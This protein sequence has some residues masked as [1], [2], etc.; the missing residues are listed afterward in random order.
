[1]FPGFSPDYFRIYSGFFFLDFSRIF[2]RFFLG[3]SRIFP[4][5]FFFFVLDFYSIFPGCFLDFSQIIPGFFSQIFS[6]DFPTIFRRFFSW[7][8]S[9]IFLQIFPI[10]PP[11]FSW[12]F[13]SR[14]FPWNST[15]RNPEISSFPVL[16]LNSLKFLG[17]PQNFLRFLRFWGRSNPN[18]SQFFPIFPRGL[19]LLRS[20]PAPLQAPGGQHLP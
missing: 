14:P 15:L 16:S 20:A 18:F 5:F 2:P 4:G 8:F 7:I 13:F 3:F 19:R 9:T 12:I 6:L 10:F 17:I 11:D 1:M